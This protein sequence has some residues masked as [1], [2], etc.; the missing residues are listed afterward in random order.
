MYIWYHILYICCVSFG[1]LTDSCIIFFL[2]MSLHM[3]A[4]KLY[5]KCCRSHFYV[6]QM[7]YS[8]ICR[9]G[10]V[11]IYI[12]LFIKIENNLVTEKTLLLFF[13]KI[14]DLIM[15]SFLFFRLNFHSGLTR[16]FRSLHL[17]YEGKQ[18]QLIKPLLV[19][20][21]IN[22]NNLIFKA[23]YKTPFPWTLLY[24]DYI[25]LC[26]NFQRVPPVGSRSRFYMCV[27]SLHV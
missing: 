4:R 20:C 11:Y 12:Y 3:Q 24:F 6:I 22:I 7:R 8:S 2:V 9:M 13:F 21:Y 26:L 19:I 23:F 1:V 25:S 18:H 15:T 10:F 5:A 17:L 14:D 27:A 16:F